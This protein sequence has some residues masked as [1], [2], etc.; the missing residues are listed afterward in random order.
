MNDELDAKK[1]RACGYRTWNREQKGKQRFSESQPT[2][3]SGLVL[4]HCFDYRSSR[5]KI[6][7]KTYG[8]DKV[9]KIASNTMRAKATMGVKRNGV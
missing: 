8:E 3:Q 1:E 5:M 4:C 2:R 7:Q 9:G 6:A